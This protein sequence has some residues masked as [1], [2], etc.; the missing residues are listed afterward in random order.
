[1][2]LILIYKYFFTIAFDNEV[3]D[4]SDKDSN[5]DD[6]QSVCDDLGPFDDS[7]S[8]SDDNEED[9]GNG[10]D[11]PLYNG[12]SISLGESIL[13]IL[14]MIIRHTINSVLLTDILKIIRL[15][16]P[17]PNIFPKS[18]YKFRKFFNRFDLSIKR[19]FF[20]SI[21]FAKFGSSTEKCQIC[22][23]SEQCYFIEISL[24]TQLCRLFK[25]V[26]FYDLLSMRFQR[27]KQSP[28]N[29]EDIYN[30]DIYKSLSSPNQFSSYHN[31]F[32]FTWN[33]D[34]I[35]LYKSSKFS[36][37]H[38]YL[39]TIELPFSQ[40][41]Q[42]IQSLIAGFWFGPTKPQANVFMNSFITSIN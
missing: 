3:D 7:D 10:F 4:D 24:I 12:A 23:N 25:R 36:I 5:D 22:Q 15:L 14:M 11:L 32:S 34:G 6:H 21:C 39:T 29:F 38:F 13:S 40:R 26:G 35:D 18:L 8:E 27:D 19:H 28:N 9:N 42:S 37:W 16:F 41:T 31:N 33:T 1:M 2:Y 17:H 20:C 30:G